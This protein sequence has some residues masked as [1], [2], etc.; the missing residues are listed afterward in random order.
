MPSPAEI[1][2]NK[3]T[4]QQL[5]RK[6]RAC[7][8]DIVNWMKEQFNYMCIYVYMQQYITLVDVVRA[9]QMIWVC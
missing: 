4:R 2:K 3:K 7:G 5:W 1:K 6:W 8:A 9:V